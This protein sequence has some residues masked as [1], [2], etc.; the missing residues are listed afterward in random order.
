MQFSKMGEDERAEIIA[1]VESAYRA[2][3]GTIRS[4]R[5]ALVEFDQILDDAEQARRPWVHDLRDQWM[6]D[7]MRSFL[8]SQ[9]KAHA[10]SYV[11]LD[12]RGRAHSRDVVRGAKVVDESTGR[13]EQSSIQLEM[14]SRDDLLNAISHAGRQIEENRLNLGQYRRLLDLLEQTAT[15][16]V[17]EALELR[18]LSLE[19]FLN[20]DAAKSA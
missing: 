9:W 3:N 11:V 1:S 13:V 18:G 10:G 2:D 8:Q 19:D 15:N 12:Q 20:E 4:H 16:T 5:A 17:G 14:W 7:G 6:R